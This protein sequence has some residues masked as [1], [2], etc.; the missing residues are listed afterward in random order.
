[1]PFVS[2]PHLDLTASRIET[3]RLVL[4]PFSLDGLVR[5]EELRD[6]FCLINQD[7]FVSQF[8]P[9]YEEEKIY[10]AKMVEQIRAGE[11]FENCVFDKN[12]MRF[13]GCAGLNRPEPNTMNIGIWIRRDEHGK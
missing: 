1:M 2:H 12:T 11:L 8:L 5:I 6:Q 10:V 7:H 9:T 13:I 4:L 3:P